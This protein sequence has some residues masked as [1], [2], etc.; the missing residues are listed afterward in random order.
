MFILLARRWYSI[1]GTDYY[2][3]NSS[4]FDTTLPSVPNALHL[5]DSSIEQ[6]LPLFNFSSL[7]RFS[8]RLAERA[9]YIQMPKNI[10]VVA[11]SCRYA[12]SEC[13]SIDCLHM[14]HSHYRGGS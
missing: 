1:L 9:N 7:S 5:G 11:L 4:N 3:I 10:C 6:C 8:R 14:Y 13:S 12:Y 2:A